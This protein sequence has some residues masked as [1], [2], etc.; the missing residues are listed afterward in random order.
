MAKLYAEHDSLPRGD[1]DPAP[2]DP[3][4]PV[5][6]VLVNAYSGLGIHTV[7]NIFRAFP[8]HFKG[9]VFVS[10]GVV[11]SGEFK[12]EDS[13]AELTIRTEEMLEQYLR[14]AA[15]LGVS[16]DYRLTIGTEAVESGEA[17]CL[18]VAQE[19]PRSTFFA[20][21]LIFERERWYQRLLHNETA[22]AI[23]KRLQW[24]GKTMVTLPVRLR[25]S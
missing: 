15:G 17:L 13:I 3:K 10:V 14:L 16:A 24:A 21:K 11:D 2:P 6:I 5:A 7:L 22:L 20:G 8:N 25:E 19:Y 9:L 12:G 18:S 1:H 4:Q 23:Q